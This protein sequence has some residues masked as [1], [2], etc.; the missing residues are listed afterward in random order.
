M[1]ASINIS[2]ACALL[3]C[4][5]IAI[6]VFFSTVDVSKDKVWAYPSDFEQYQPQSKVLTPDTLSRALIEL[7]GETLTI[8]SEIH[9]L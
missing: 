2:V 4:S 5:L 6:A 9:E 1:R 7:R 8:S 3:Y